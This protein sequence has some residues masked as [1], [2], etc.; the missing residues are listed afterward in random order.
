MVTKRLVFTAGRVLSKPKRHVLSGNLAFVP[1]LMFLGNIWVRTQVYWNKSAGG[2]VSY[3]CP[4]CASEG[5]AFE[6]STTREIGNIR[7]KGEVVELKVLL[8]SHECPNKACGKRY[9]ILKGKN[10]IP[11][12]FDDFP[13]VEV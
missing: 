11:A 1:A 12:D 5:Y 13:Y 7:F 2:K 6:L 3:L 10:E 8:T 9:V 4:F